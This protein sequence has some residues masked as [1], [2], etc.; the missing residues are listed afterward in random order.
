MSA[1]E[2]KR[3]CLRSLSY[4]SHKT[5]DSNKS[6]WLW[7]CFLRGARIPPGYCWPTP[8]YRNWCVQHAFLEGQKAE[9]TSSRKSTPRTLKGVD[10]QYPPVSST[11]AAQPLLAP[12]HAQKL[13]L[14]TCV[15][16]TRRVTR[17]W[18]PERSWLC[19]LQIIYHPQS[20][21]FED[22]PLKGGTEEGYP[23]KGGMRGHAS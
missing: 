18:T 2:A 19:W 4:W 8:K 22:T 9:G 21:G 10:Q 15:A 13:S 1:S 5:L 16:L 7:R 11:H 6:V 12:D 14:E 23:L 3:C 20:G 17:C